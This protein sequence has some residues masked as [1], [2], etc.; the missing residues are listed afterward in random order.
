M[1]KLLFLLI[2]TFVAMSVS[3]GPVDQV[4][5]QRK[6]R[7]YLANE[8]YAG[9]IMAPAALNPVLLKAE[10]RDAKR[11]QPVY[12]IYNT[13]TTFL[14]I[15]GDDR[16]EEILMVGDRPL[17]DINHLA[18]AMQDILNMYKE[19]INYLF[20]HPNIKVERPSEQN[21][22]LRAVTY[23]PLLTAEW[24]QDAPYNNLCKFTYNNRVYTCLTG[25]PATSAAMVMYHW[26][27]PA[28]VGAMASY[29]STLDIGY[30]QS[31][32]FTYPALD[33]TTFD[34]ANMKDKYTSYNS[35]QATAVATLMRYIGQAEKMMYG[36]E[37]AGGSGIYTNETYKVVNMFKD[38][39]Y[40]STVAVKY[41][42]SYSAT[43]WAN[44]LIAELAAGRPMIYNGVSTSGGGHA[45]N[46]DGY[47]DSD[48]KWH[49]N[50]GWSGDG[51][52]WYSMNSFSYGGYTF[53]SDQ[54]AVIGIEPAENV[55]TPVL[56]VNPTSLSFTGETG[57]TYTQTF[58]VSGTDLTGNVTISSSNSRFTVSPST[59]TAAQAMAG[60]TITVTY[61]PTTATT[62]NGTIT[63]ASTGAESKTVSVT[64]T[65][66]APGP[67]LVADPNS[68]S[69]TTT[70]GTSVSQTFHLTGTNLSGIV[71]LSCS[72]D[73]FS[74]NPTAISK[75]AATNGYD[76][77]VTYDPETSG[78]HTGTVT[79]SSTGAQNIT[80]A[81]TGT[82]TASPVITVNPTSLSFSTTV[83]Q[84]VTKTFTVS[85]S[86]L[87]G[88]I[89]L[90]CSGTGFSIDKTTINRNTALN[91]TTVTVTYNPTA[92]GSHTGTVT[93]TSDGAATKT[94]TLTGSASTVPTVTANPTSL[95][96]NA[97]IGTPVTKT[98]TL[99]GTNLV[100]GVNLAV[101]GTGFTIDKTY[102]NNS[103]ATSGTTV[104]VT[105]NPTAAGNHTGT[106]TLTSSGAQAVTVALNGTATEPV[107]TITATPTA[108]NFTT[109]V[110]ETVTQNF[111]VSGENLT[112][113]LTLTLNDA[114]GVYSI[115]PTTISA[116]AAM[117]G[118][119]PVT[120]TYTPGSFGMHAA[121]VTIAGGGAPAATVTLNGQA[122]LIKYA[123]VML[124]AN[125]T[126]INLTKFR[127]DWTDATPEANVASYTLEVS[128]KAVEPEPEVVELLAT[129][130]GTAYTGNYQ[131]VTLPAPWSGN[132]VFGGSG[133][134]YFR[135]ATHQQATTDGYI[136]FTIPE[137]YENKTFTLKLTTANTN[138]GSGRFVVGSTQ[139]TA[140]EYNMSK[141][142]THSWVVTG[143]TG[144]EIT[145]TSPEDQY[146]PDIAT[147]EVYSGDATAAK[148]MANERGDA[149]Y[150][151]ITGITDKFYTVNDLT[152]EGTFEFKVKA[153][154][155]DGTE[156]DWSN[157]EEVTLF[158]NGHGYELGDVNHDGNINIGDVTLLISYVLS[159]GTGAGCPICGDMNED[160]TVNV[161]DVTAL[162]AK[163][164]NGGSSS[165]AVMMMGSN[166]LF[167]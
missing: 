66:T 105:Y 155:K 76:I 167:R 159:N 48:S 3:A 138:Y 63:V 142:E 128:T 101:S 6:A 151:L 158:E 114:N 146:S 162:I 108:L 57:S 27:C 56:S 73:D 52:S 72:G 91:G 96:F 86:D 109:M 165:S 133:A 115:N 58:T 79:I 154:Y 15:A 121:T 30:N 127:A 17:K 157:I 42:S 135:N 53:S 8:M 136:K 68:L 140:V 5:A 112:G 99:T 51:N 32:N 100:G 98:F 125:E 150:R 103:T 160:G 37:A 139:T 71:N 60:A 134:L 43:N 67:K 153:I 163:V 113:D 141:N 97:V 4:A 46:V 148:L 116:A 35:A 59:L 88:N 31:V 20:D 75:T 117:A 81:L 19:E 129:I 14:V 106:V 130:D 122:D 11:S 24:D 7:N 22:S 64:G 89:S 41:K 107:R 50:F 29:S 45:F 82:A 55:P 80:V 126:Y 93:L 137:G 102:V 13:S 145:I 83:G 123:P 2:A 44:L 164:L 62:S 132:N 152:A 39:G 61:A 54:Q 111:N 124:P 77:T 147:L 12:Y 92:G 144:E 87:T 70:V 119:V 10:P 104:T 118:N 110:S 84:A 78:T 18:P 90:S 95:N 21:T 49:V 149:T 33:A 74:V 47:R 40:A 120:V 16:A 23:G 131:A 9:K 1:K 28:G 94:V 161:G 25:C 26:K 156:S 143:S 65:A 36:T 85:G 38:W 34:W 69:F 166:H